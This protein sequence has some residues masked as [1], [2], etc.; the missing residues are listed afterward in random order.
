MF[1]VDVSQAAVSSQRST[2]VNIANTLVI[3]RKAS[4]CYGHVIPLLTARRQIV[5]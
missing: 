2:K 5:K 4:G 1:V 3:R